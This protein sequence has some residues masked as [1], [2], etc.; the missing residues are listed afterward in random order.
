MAQRLTGGI[1]SPE[2][3]FNDTDP[4]TLNDLKPLS[5]EAVIRVP[6]PDGKFYCFQKPSLQNWRKVN[7]TKNPATNLE[8][9][10][11]QR[12]VIE[13]E[14]GMYWVMKID[15]RVRV[16]D[17]YVVDK[18]NL[19]TQPPFSGYAFAPTFALR[20][21][22]MVRFEELMKSELQSQT[23]APFHRDMRILKL[24]YF[25]RE[26]DVLVPSPGETALAVYPIVVLAF[27][28]NSSVYLPEISQMGTL[29]ARAYIKAIMPEQRERQ[30]LPIDFFTGAQGQVRAFDYRVP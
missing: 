16:N 9:T 6:G 5:D 14:L 23:L 15:I 18:E 1:T 7:P 19:I 24:K 28:K 20:N 11:A 4:I 17:K 3:C 12:I 8:W 30:N 21:Q 2:T 13:N 22:F 29:A 10:E 26:D 25:P 27:V